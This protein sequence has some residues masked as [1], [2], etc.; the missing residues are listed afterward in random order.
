VQSGALSKE[1]IN[2]ELD[3]LHGWNAWRLFEILRC[4]QVP[5]MAIMT[6]RVDH[7]A[8]SQ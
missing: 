6:L 5:P 1:D 3:K 2:K 4:P 8:A 7:Q